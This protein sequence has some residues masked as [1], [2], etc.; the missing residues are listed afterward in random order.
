MRLGPEKSSRSVSIDFVWNLCETT[1]LARYHPL[2]RGLSTHLLNPQLSSS[3]SA[4]LDRLREIVLP[5]LVNLF[6]MLSGSFEIACNFYK[7]ILFCAVLKCWDVRDVDQFRQFFLACCGCS[8]GEVRMIFGRNDSLPNR[9]L[10]NGFKL[11]LVVSCWV[12][13]P[14][15]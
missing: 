8:E 12:D 1:V 5:C 2:T 4:V 14:V 6:D 11:Y 13:W 15:A 7:Q 10:Q 9:S 3:I